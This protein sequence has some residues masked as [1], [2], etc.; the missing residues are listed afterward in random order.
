MEDKI[1]QILKQFD[2]LLTEIVLLS[3]DEMRLVLSEISH[4]LDE[5]KAEI[6]EGLPPPLFVELAP[7]ACTGDEDPN[8]LVV[9][10]DESN[11]K[12]EED[13]GGNLAG[14][15]IVS[16]EINCV[17]VVPPSGS[18]LD[19]DQRDTDDGDGGGD[20]RQTVCV[21]VASGDE[22]TENRS[23]S[24]NELEGEPT[25]ADSD[26]DDA[27]LDV[28]RPTGASTKQTGRS[29]SYCDQEFNTKSSLA[30]HMRTIH[31]SV[32]VDV[33]SCGSC[34]RQ[35]RSHNGL[36]YHVQSK[37]AAEEAAPRYRCERPE[38]QYR[39]GSRVLLRAHLY[40]HTVNAP[41]TCPVCGKDFLGEFL[42]C[43]GL[44]YFSKM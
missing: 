8:G 25:G 15:E 10:L 18:G 4:K 38:C 37:H 2:I 13:S 40:S 42:I 20:S 33:Y 31:R 39:T 24:D 32:S 30:A 44:K 5:I 12:A 34:N 43:A 17:W 21:K 36:I 41:L 14:N 22:Y 19:G 7:S 28:W 35:F 3:L 1:V 9:V 29:C 26:P 6:G 16:G 23:D 27:G 11:F